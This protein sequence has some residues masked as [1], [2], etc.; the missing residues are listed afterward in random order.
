MPDMRAAERLARLA[1][2]WP[3]DVV[4]AA[5]LAVGLLGYLA[6]QGGWHGR[7]DLF[8]TACGL[9]AC[10]CVA[11]RRR[12]PKAAG[13]AAACCFG[14]TALGDSN[15]LPD[16]LFFVPLSLIAYSL[17]AAD[18][19]VL[20][21]A[22]LVALWAGT[23][24]AT[25]F[26]VFN[27]FDVVA[28]VGAWA[29]GLAVRSRR[30]VADQLAVRGR[31]LEA[32]R[33]LFAAEAIRYER[34]RIARELHDIVAHNISVMVIQAGAGQRLA[35]SDPALTAEAFDAIAESAR[36]A[37][38][39]I[40]RLVEMLDQRPGDGSG[41]G[42]IE[43]V[44][45]LVARAAAAGLAVSCRISPAVSGMTGRAS[46][47]A[48]R[49]VQEALTNALKHAPGARVEVGIDGSGDE[50]RV[51]VGN[52]PAAQPVSALHT[53]G[54]GNGLA[55]MR[56][57]AQVCGGELTAGPDGRGGWLVV[58]RLPVRPQMEAREPDSVLRQTRPA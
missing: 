45:E 31:E 9:A 35:G 51:R 13:L 33:E 36:Q 44:D 52:G 43:L 16:D 29:L 17:G 50:L 18:D 15:V 58:A 5:L 25:G 32:E 40:G 20:A 2:R 7:N 6:S 3:A 27:P 55:G 21:A 10:A 41:S 47:T 34:A 57:R 53:V 14:L 54:G 24:L 28:T 38:A 22:V 42:G 56:D 23:Q 49:V 46:E 37:E 39:E 8:E 26:T 11:I 48:Y 4:V 30:R 1:G 12:Y 19:T